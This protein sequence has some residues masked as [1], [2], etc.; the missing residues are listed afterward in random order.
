MSIKIGICGAGAFAKHFIPLFKAHPHVEDVIL[1][2]LD[3][4]KRKQ[5]SEEFDL[6]NTCPSL[7]ELCQTDVDAIALFT[8][9]WLHGPQAAQALRAGKDVYSAVPSAVTMEEITDLVKAVEETGRI[10]MIGETSYYYP[11]TIYCRQRWRAGDFGRMVYCEAAYLHDF[12]HGLYDVCKWRGG[13][14]WRNIAGMPPMYYPTHS[15][16]IPVCVAGERM[17]HVS[18]QGFVDDHEDGLF[19]KDVNQWKNE[20]SDEIALF[21]MSNGASARIGEF[22]RVGH[23]GEVRCS[24]FGTEGSYEEQP[25]SKVWVTKQQGPEHILRLNEE[26]D[27]GNIPA[28][29]SGDDMDK[30]AGDAHRGAARVHPLDRLPKEYVG[31]GNGHKGSHQFLIDDFVRACVTRKQPPCNVHQAARYLVPGLIAHQSALQGGTLLEIPD[32]GPGPDTSDWP[33]ECE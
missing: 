22:R 20:F 5:T 24:F 16:S 26:L 18:C 4:D 15:V 12:D 21:R 8:Q 6:P 33:P 32:F 7:D 28:S 23:P 9:N 3:P 1:C 31:L 10:Y 11:C 2:D 25:D 13:K 19:R 29:A 30:V 14:N 27:C 17:T